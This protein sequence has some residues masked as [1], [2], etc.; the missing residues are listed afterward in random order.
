MPRFVDPTKQETIGSLKLW[1]RPNTTKGLPPNWVIADGSTIID[2]DSPFNGVA[3]P[4]TVNRFP[5]GPP[6][7]TNSSGLGAYESGATVTGGASS[8][9]IDF[10][11]NH[12]QNS[13]NHTVN[14]HNHTI[15]NDGSHSH[16]SSGSDG[17]DPNV[18]GVGTTTEPDHNHT[19]NTGNATPGTNSQTPT[20]FSNLGNTDIRPQYSQL[21]YIVKIK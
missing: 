7:I 15:S 12:N 19:G 9:T 16:T 14:S 18:G 3:V 13:H 20:I 8:H 5:Q 17:F 1:T 10:S 2:P 11:H 6:S 21:V 4:S